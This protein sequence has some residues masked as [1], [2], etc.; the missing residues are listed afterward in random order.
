VA[1]AL[2]AGVLV[3]ASA[4]TSA[5]APPAHRPA[6]AGPTA[7]GPGRP[8]EVASGP[9]AGG[10][11]RVALPAQWSAALRAGQVR[12]RDGERVVVRAGSADGR[13][14]FVE[15]S[16]PGWR[17]L[18]WLR[19]EGRTRTEI[20]AV[21]DPEHEQ[22]VAAAFD[23]RWLVFGVG[24]RLGEPDDWTLYS[25]DSSA[26]GAPRQIARNTEH[27]PWLAP[28]VRDGRA[29]WIAGAPA[30]QA[31]VHLYDLGRD[32][33]RVVHDGPANTVFFASELLVWRAGYDDVPAALAAVSAATGAP[34]QLPAQLR[35]VRS[36]HYVTGNGTTFVWTLP[37]QR[38]IQAWRTGWAEPRRV[39]T[40]A[41]NTVE[42][43]KISGDL[44]A[45]GDTEAR[46]VAD[47]RSGSYVQITP[48]FGWTD[49]WD[50][51][52]LVQ[53]APDAEASAAST[54]IRAN[55]LEPLPRCH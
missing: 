13:S 16:R 1:G 39:I 25:W 45:W 50:D 27:A 54:V 8:P 15:L 6:G 30:L 20:M 19:D 42:W 55:G 31:R 12:T 47:L 29:A 21:A 3:T 26:G 9:A 38:T 52:L 43:P 10:T 23:G 36:G 40:L 33:D 22:V 11:C 53:Y 41:E 48:R 14:Q 2:V 46:F 18:V 7:A 24:H 5:P 4:C 35:T 34:A 32:V 37:D 51:V 28:V 44:V 49:A 17:G